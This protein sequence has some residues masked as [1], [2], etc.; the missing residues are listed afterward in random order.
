MRPSRKTGLD[1]P[2]LKTQKRAAHK[3]GL[4]TPVKKHAPAAGAFKA[5]VKATN[6]LSKGDVDR[7]SHKSARSNDSGKMSCQSVVNTYFP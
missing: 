6:Q 2:N 3:A 5:T 7:I 4:L 1:T